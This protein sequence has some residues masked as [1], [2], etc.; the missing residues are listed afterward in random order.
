MLILSYSGLAKVQAKLCN[1]PHESQQ[2]KLLVFGYLTFAL[3]FICMLVRIVSK[4][5]MG[6]KLGIDDWLI[7]ATEV[8]SS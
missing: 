7:V 8:R 3:A 1:K 5:Y 4:I 2:T 6:I